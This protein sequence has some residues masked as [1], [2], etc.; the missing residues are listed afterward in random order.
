MIAR[1]GSPASARAAAL[2]AATLLSPMPHALASA[3]P[4]PREEWLEARTPNFLVFSNAKARKTREIALGLERFRAVLEH[5]RPG[6]RA[7]SPVPVTIFLFKDDRS[8]RPYKDVL[9][10]GTKPRVGHFFRTGAGAYILLN[11][12]PP[13][14]GGPQVVYHEY[15]HLF[16]QNNVQ[17]LPLW[18]GEGLA[19]YYS[20]V[21][22]ARDEV[23]VGRPLADHVSWLRKSSFLPLAQLFAVGHDSPEYNES[24]RAGPFYAQSWL[25]VHYLMDRA[26][27]EGPAKI[28][29]F[30]DSLADGE[31]PEEASR[32]ALDMDL[33]ALERALRGY[34]NKPRFESARLRHTELTP[35]PEVAVR[36]AE[37]S[38]LLIALA[39]YLAQVQSE[40]GRAARAH[41]AAA[42]AAAP[43]DGDALAIEA[44]LDAREGRREEA[45]ERF[46]RA[47]AASP[48]RAWSLVLYPGHRLRQGA[49]SASVQELAMLRAA[50]ER[51]TQL[52]PGFGE[53]HALLGFSH[54]TGPGE[55]A[56]IGRRALERASEL[57]PARSDV[58][59]NLA[60]LQAEA[61]EFVAARVTILGRLAREPEL[62]RQALTAVEQA[63][64]I[65]VAN[66]RLERGDGEAALAALRAARDR[67][68]DPQARRELELRIQN[69]EKQVFHNAEVDLY[70]EAVTL[71]NS[72]R[73]ADAQRILTRLLDDARSPE[74]RE[75]AQE[76]LAKIEDVV[77]EP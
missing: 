13:R 76:L 70:N 35:E 39:G 18:L 64:A 25:L 60:V 77:H 44:Y 66:E 23:Q 32:S 55:G 31:S 67:V 58:A 69:V 15:T 73:L 71:A 30:L 74:V 36:P 65:A 6:M 51:A 48:R 72:G 16:F 53:A 59:Y 1:S 47:L 24:T 11:V 7:T 28:N 49:S 40:D 37:L 52:D 42:L 29:G 2:L 50:L 46:A 10:G 41:V 19:E 14:G 62:R 27:D 63:E 61:G 38:D 34:V 20:T 17:N 75:A 26:R 9:P 21:E 8:Y 68:E 57:L 43:G 33:V 56:A 22:I 4:D 54:L 3:P 12:Y 45:A 5:L